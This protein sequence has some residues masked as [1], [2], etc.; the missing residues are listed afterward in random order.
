MAS[1]QVMGHCQAMLG[2]NAWVP[3]VRES[4]SRDN[5][6][7]IAGG[8]AP[9]KPT[10]PFG[11]IKAE[12]DP[13]RP[14]VALECGPFAGRAPRPRPDPAESYANGSM[15]SN[16]DVMMRNGMYGVSVDDHT[17]MGAGM[18]RVQEA[19]ASGPGQAI[20]DGSSSVGTSSM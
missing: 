6:H 13:A 12:V 19:V 17:A 14:E 11:G 2:M 3:T 7:L 18:E 15:N 4:G 10:E 9:V 20:Y 8:G 16:G 5:L 1:V